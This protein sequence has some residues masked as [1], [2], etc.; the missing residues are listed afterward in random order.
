MYPTDSNS[1]DLRCRYLKDDSPNGIIDCPDGW[2]YSNVNDPDGSKW[3]F[4]GG[5]LGNGAGEY[6]SGN[7]QAG[8]GGGGKRSLS[9]HDMSLLFTV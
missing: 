3:N 6:D 9:C 7:P 4:K 1:A 8:L 2:Y 5:G